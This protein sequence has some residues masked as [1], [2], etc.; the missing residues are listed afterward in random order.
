MNT[1]NL[2]QGMIIKNFKELCNILEIPAKVGRSKTLQLID[3]NRYFTY[4]KQGQKFIITKILEEPLP[5]IDHRKDID[6]NG[7][8]SKYVE[9]IKAL[10]LNQLLISDEHGY[11]LTKNNL[12]EFLGMVNKLYLQKDIAKQI[13]PKQDSNIT[14]HDI[15]H[16]Y[17][18][19]NGKLTKILFDSLNS[20]QRKYLIKYREINIIVRVND[21]GIEK[22]TEATREEELILL[23]AKFNALVEMGLENIMQVVLKF[24][25][26]EYYKKVNKLL[27]I[28]N[29]KYS[30]KQ[31]ELLFNKKDVLLQLSLMEISENRKELN[32]KII[33][34]INQNAERVYS[35]KLRRL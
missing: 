3:F 17:M 1:S 25:T 20:L 30:Y 18:R 6:K 32:D 34:A 13:L 24:K 27:N 9:N 33:N 28:S 10:I 8:H 7:N 15:N 29:I 31:I 16:F 2:Y 26:E 12:F 35:K 14:E 22:H 23:S 21:K 5:K 11:T 19:T 4:T